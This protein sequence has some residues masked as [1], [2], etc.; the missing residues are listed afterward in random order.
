LLTARIPSDDDVE[1]TIKIDL[2]AAIQT[3]RSTFSPWTLSL[4]D[5]RVF[6]VRAPSVVVGRR[7]T[8]S[9]PGVQALAVADA[10]RTLSRNHAR[11]DLVDGVWRVTDLG[12]TN[13]VVVTDTDGKEMK[14]AP[15]SP[16]PVYRYVAFGSVEARL[17]AGS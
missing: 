14:A 2:E 10:T 9:I 11:L 16:T 8:A 7:P 6:A 5:G 12:S 1:V 13:G 15:G 17:V 3:D 4:G